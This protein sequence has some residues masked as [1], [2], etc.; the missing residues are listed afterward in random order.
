MA[1]VRQ[2]KPEFFLHEE[3]AEL[4]MGARLL[5]IGLWTIADKAG[6]LKNRPARIKAQIFPY[7]TVDCSALLDEL[8][9][10]G[11][12]Y[13]YTAEDSDATGDYI[14]IRNFLK[15][16]HPH[17]KEQESEIPSPTRE[18]RKEIAG[19]VLPVQAVERRES[20]DV[21]PPASPSDSG[22]GDRNLDSGSGDGSPAPARSNEQANVTGYDLLR[23][24]SQRRAMRLGGLPWKTPADPEGKATRFAEAM[25]PDEIGDIDGTLD[26]AFE[27][28]RT[29]APRWS[30]ERL[31]KSHAFGFGAWV[32]EFSALREAL[33]GVAPT[34]APARAP[35]PPSRDVRIG[36]VRASDEYTAEIGE[37]KI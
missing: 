16:Q 23:R 36:S 4:T 5:F 2:I 24:F 29:R 11:F 28:I 17:P 31:S 10:C 37:Q 25:S 13:R 19:N 20:R 21:S 15:H 1:R 26:L 35:P 3:L 33:H 22:S 18:P 32:S 7:D 12:I 27:L 9:T 6:R 8:G 14:Q 34:V 30:D